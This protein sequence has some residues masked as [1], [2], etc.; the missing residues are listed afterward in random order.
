LSGA[1]NA[2]CQNYVVFVVHVEFCYTCR[3]KTSLFFLSVIYLLAGSSLLSFYNSH[4]WF[5]AGGAIG[6]AHYDVIDDVI[7]RKL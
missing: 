7:T 5:T 1:V 2:A 6:I 3:M 4:T